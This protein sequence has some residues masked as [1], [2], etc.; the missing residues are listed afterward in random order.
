MI[1]HF[2]DIEDFSKKQLD[3]IIDQA[4]KIKAN[5]NKYK[6]LM[7]NKSLGL[8]FQKESTR[9]RLSF[10]IG[11][12]KMGGNVI[13]LNANHIGLGKRESEEDILRV[14][15]QYID[16]LVIRNNNHGKIKSP[17]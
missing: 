17:S 2:I 15:S 6:N 11:M 5:L 9:T 12:Q 13:E 3:F 7:N 10:S 4:K 8:L 1:N 14:L 16:F